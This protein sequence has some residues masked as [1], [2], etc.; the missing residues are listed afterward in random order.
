[1]PNVRDV[2]DQLSTTENHRLTVDEVLDR[3]ELHFSAEESRRQL[4]ALIEW[5]RYAEAFAFDAP[6]GLLTPR[7]QLHHK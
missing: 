1:M 2:V 6:A 7:E 4:E 3:L 5:G